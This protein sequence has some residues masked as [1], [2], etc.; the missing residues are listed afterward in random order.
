LIVKDIKLSENYVK[1]HFCEYDYDYCRHDKKTFSFWWDVDF[2]LQFK[3]TFFRHLGCV[4]FLTACAC[5]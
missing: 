1:A 5:R 2:R 3:F 4:F